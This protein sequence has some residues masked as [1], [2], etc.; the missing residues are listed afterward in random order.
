M[1]LHRTAQPHLSRQVLFGVVAFLSL[2]ACGGSD[3][4]ESQSAPKASAT[5]T[6]E[7]ELP[8]VE[9]L[10]E[11][12]GSR[13][14]VPA[15]DWIQVVDGSAWTT[16]ASKA[17]VRLEPGAGK[18]TARVPA[19]EESCLAMDVSFGSL[20]VGICSAPSIVLRIH[21]GTAEVQA[22]IKLPGRLL[23]EEGSLGAGSGSVWAVT[24]GQDESEGRKLLRIDP[25]TNRVTARFAAPDGVAGARAGLGGLWLTDPEGGSV[26]RI[27]PAAGGT[28]GTVKTGAEARFFAVGEGGVWVQNNVDGTVTRIDPRSNRVIATIKVDEFPIS[29]GDL[30]IG[31]GFVWARVS[32][33]LVAQID[34]RTNTVVAR[35]GP[36]GGSGSVAADA[37]AVW[38]T[39]H[40]GNAVYR[41][42]LG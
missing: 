24:M 37:E 1:A 8:A 38:V 27:D 22:T 34:P 3:V 6:P 26:V 12:G 25:E 9:D 40:D 5:S 21:P 2:V 10:V 4:E 41:L 7:G 42:P 14:E 18:E 32:S 16:L 19:T 23:V 17:I 39:A 11:A 20:W 31:G 33:A 29:G 30:A 13:F 36:A 15:A 28:I 35:Y